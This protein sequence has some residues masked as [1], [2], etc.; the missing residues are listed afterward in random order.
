MNFQPMMKRE[1]FAQRESDSIMRVS[2]KCDETL[3]M[4]VYLLEDREIVILD[5]VLQHKD[6]KHK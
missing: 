3:W 2:M 4:N 6:G 5:F 1:I